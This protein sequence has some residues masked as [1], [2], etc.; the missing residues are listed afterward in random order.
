MP[1]VHVEHVDVL[2]LRPHVE[3]RREEGLGQAGDA[4]DVVGLVTIQDV[5]QVARL[6]DKP[7]DDLAD[8]LDLAVDLGL[9]GVVGLLLLL[10]EELFLVAQFDHIVAERA[11]AAAR[12]F[13]ALVSLAVAPVLGAGNEPAFARLAELAG[14]DANGVLF[15]VLGDF[16]KVEGSAAGVLASGGLG[17]G[18][19]LGVDGSWHG[20]DVS[21]G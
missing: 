9:S 20:G 2:G 15:T 16:V 8:L 21:V 4:D 13:G 6:G 1:L 12:L 14:K 3:D 7:A 18:K 5:D 11:G 10:L 19:K 17:F